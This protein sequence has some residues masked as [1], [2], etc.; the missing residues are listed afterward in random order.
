MTQITLTS[1]LAA[2]LQEVDRIVRERTRSRA[3]VISVAGSRLLQADAERLRAALVLLSADLIGDY[4]SERVLHAAAA[5]EL[6]YAATQTHDDLVDAAERRRGVPRTDE[7]SDGVALMVGDYLFAL[8][9]VEMALSPDARVIGIYSHAVMQICEAQ[10]APAAALHPL[11]QA[12]EQHIAQ[13]AGTTAALLGAACR[14]GGICSGA[15]P[16]QI[17]A[18]GLFGERLGL[19]RTIA[20]ELRE[21]VAH[22]GGSAPSLG[23]GLVTLPLIYAADSGDGARLAAALDSSDPAELSWATGEVQALGLAPARAELAHRAA[24]AR[25]ALAAFP[26]TPARAALLA[27]TDASLWG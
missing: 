8:A 24:A 27:L 17:E 20:A 12:S 4:A 23:R 6:I 16:E 26:D 18:L 2:D 15:T 10:L 21:F 11:P 1:T 3:A 9:A 22:D 7:W 25:A 5:V 19:V 13:I 14:A